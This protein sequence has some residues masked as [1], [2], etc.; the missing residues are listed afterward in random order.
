MN[1]KNFNLDLFRARAYHNL[2]HSSITSENWEKAFAESVN[3]K[4]VKGT[5][6]LADAYDND[7]VYNI[8]SRKIDPQIKKRIDNRDFITHPNFYHFGGHKP[9]EVDLD[10]IHTVAGRV[11]IS[12]FDDQT[13]PPIEIGKKTLERYQTFEEA[14]LERFECDETRD[15]VIIHGLSHD[16][17]NYLLRIMFFNHILNPIKKWDACTFNGPRTKWKGKRGAIIGYDEHGPHIGRN[18]D[19]GRA[20]T[21]MI[22]FYRKSEALHIIETQVPVPKPPKFD[23]NRIKN[24]IR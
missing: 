20:N 13:C 7:Y 3:G 2:E 10:N 8:K 9:V 16:Q 12:D 14:S 24:I 11:S 15:I 5:K 22:R 4:W 1:L 21:C 19:I 23:F 17:R 6:Y 18:P